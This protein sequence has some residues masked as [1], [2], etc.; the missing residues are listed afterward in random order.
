MVL[1]Q[2]VCAGVQM[3]IAGTALHGFSLCTLA[4]DVQSAG[5]QT[6][7]LSRSKQVSPIS[8]QTSEGCGVAKVPG[9]ASGAGANGSGTSGGM[10]CGAGACVPQGYVPNAGRGP[11]GWPSCRAARRNGPRSQPVDLYT[12]RDAGQSWSD[13]GQSMRDRA[14]GWTRTQPD[15]SPQTDWTDEMGNRRCQEHGRLNCSHCR[16]WWDEQC[17]LFNARN[18][19]QGGILRAHIHGKLAY[20]H[21]MGN[22]GE[23]APPFGCWWSSRSCCR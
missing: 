14:V 9:C 19:E 17:A 22:G 23:G 13:A 21:P 12:F 7:N 8:F 10:N 3:L 1:K 5:Y 11:C 4:D 20:F 18:C 2:L 16:G 15:W 6:S